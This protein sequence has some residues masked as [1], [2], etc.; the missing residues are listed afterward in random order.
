MA[1]T[2]TDSASEQAEDTTPAVDESQVL[3]ALRKIIDPDLHRDIVSLGMIKDLAVERRP[4]GS[5]VAF[6]FELTTPACPVRNQFEAAAREAVE[7]IPGVESVDVSM[8]ANVRQAQGGASGHQI[9]LPNVRNII[10]VASGKGG[11][12]KS[13]V[14]ANMAVALAEAGATVG[15]LD[16]DVYGPSVPQLMGVYEGIKAEDG[17]MVPNEAYG[18]KLISLGFIAGDKP[19]MWRGPMIGHA[20]KQLLEDVNWGSLDYL[21]IDLPPGTGDAQISLAQLIPMTGVVIVSTP[22][23]LALGI[24]QKALLMF[25][26]LHVP[27]LGIVENMS[28]YCC[29]NCGHEADIFGSGGPQAAA[30]SMKVPFLGRVPLNL[31]IRESG[32][33]GIPVPVSAAGSPAAQAFEGIARKSAAQISIRNQ[34]AIPLTVR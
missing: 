31:S 28:T 22:Q 21:V 8:T 33:S 15:L 27:I 13:T 32:D 16:A 26:Q 29:P 2:F 23:D 4:E 11:V 25:K 7:A 17:K 20:L 18:V 6:T 24:A 9:N 19:V 30:E 34:R 14:A 3:D 5:H 10:A 1:V 12:G